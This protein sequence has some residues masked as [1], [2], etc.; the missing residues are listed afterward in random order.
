MLIVNA[1]P[2]GL[3]YD[4]SSSCYVAIED[5]ES[6]LAKLRLVKSTDPDGLPETF[7]YHLRSVLCYPLLFIFN[8]SLSEGLFPDILKVS[9]VSHILKSGDKSNVSN[10]RPISKICHLAKLFESL[11]LQSI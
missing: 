7:L 1:L 6:G 9:S 4:L 11:V 8:K 3:P 10:Y 2:N 5:V